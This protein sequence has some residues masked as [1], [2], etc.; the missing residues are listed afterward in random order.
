MRICCILHWKWNKLNGI[1]VWTC[2]SKHFLGYSISESAGM[3]IHLREEMT[4]KELRPT[5]EGT[6]GGIGLPTKEEKNCDLAWKANRKRGER[7]RTTIQF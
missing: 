5:S 4:R 3:R 2:D 6:Y 7:N 1:K